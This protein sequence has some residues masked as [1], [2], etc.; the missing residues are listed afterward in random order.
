[1]PDHADA[2]TAEP[3]TT[4]DRRDRRRQRILDAAFALL[5]RHG[6]SRTSM[7]AIAREAGAS[8][9][10]LYSY[11]GDK[12]GLF[13]ALVQANADR[14]SAGIAPS[15][16][17]SRQADI[18]GLLA[19]FGRRLLTLLMAEPG[20]AINRVAAAEAQSNPELGR[21]LLAHGRGR[22]GG[23]IIGRLA[24]AH[25]AGQLDCP[26]PDEAFDV[27][28]GLLLRDT[29]LRVIQGAVPALTDAQIADRA[30]TASR[31]FLRLYGR[32]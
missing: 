28:I 7:L 27:F 3:M 22:A 24:A 19:D 30:D 2:P 15:A 4:E 29:Q 32:S 20:I 18:A 25:E 6:Y 8:K 11:F 13:E 26:D 16:D 17:A 12:K 10:T 21:I 1:M 9:E 23:A 31:L 14:M 5:S